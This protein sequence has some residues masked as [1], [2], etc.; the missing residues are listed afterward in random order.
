V[1]LAQT[2][3]HSGTRQ[4]LLRTLLILSLALNLFFVIGALW[5]RIHAPPPPL[6]PEQRLEQMAGELGLNP[7]QRQAFE[8]YSQTM[9][10]RLQSMHDAVGPLLAAAWSEMAKPQAD[11]TKIMQLV[12]KVAERRRGFVHDLTATTLSFLTTLSPAQRAEFVRLA[13]QRP[14]P[15]APPQDH[16][17]PR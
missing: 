5:I 7:Q 11:E 2:A 1:T 13:H 8:H 14:R 17:G 16:D 10:D 4:H 9:H 6:T 3:T 12:D 15:W